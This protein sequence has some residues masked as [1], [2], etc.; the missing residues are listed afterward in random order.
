MVKRDEYNWPNW[1][2][3]S[4]TNALDTRIKI[5]VLLGCC[6]FL[7][8]REN[9]IQYFPFSSLGIF[10]ILEGHDVTHC[11]GNGLDVASNNLIKVLKFLI[12]MD[13]KKINE[14]LNMNEIIHRLTRGR[15]LQARYKDDIF[16]HFNM[17][18]AWTGHG[19]PHAKIP[20]TNV[21]MW[22]QLFKFSRTFPQQLSKKIKENYRL[23]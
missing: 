22:R 19:G 8:F 3:F 20:E 7:L 4:S 16:G 15:N 2:C 5:K 13:K 17:P 18:Q 6:F 14:I 21:K 12:G 11:G 9:F 10:V 23:P 1:Y